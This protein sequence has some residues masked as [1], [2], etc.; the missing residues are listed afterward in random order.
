MQHDGPSDATIVAADSP[1]LEQPTI[2]VSTHLPRISTARWSIAEMIRAYPS[3][4]PVPKVSALAGRAILAQ[5]IEEHERRGTPLVI[6]DYN[7]HS[8]W[9]HEIFTLEWLLQTSGDQQ[10][11]V[12]NMHDRSDHTMTLAEFV[13]ISRA[14]K[15]HSTPGELRRLYWK[16]ADCPLPWREWL[17]KKSI[18]SPGVLPGSRDDYLGYLSASEAVESLLCYMGIGDTYTAAHKDLCCSSGHNLMCFAEENASSYWFMTAADDASAAARYFHKELKQELDW[19]THV[20]SLEELGKAPFPVYVVEQCVG[21]LILVPPR[22]C[23]QVV[24]SGGLA[25]KTSWS[26]M[27][28]DSL[29]TALHSELPIYRRVCRPEQYRAALSHLVWSEETQ[30]SSILD[31]NPSTDSHLCV[32]LPL[33]TIADRAQ[34]LRRLVGLFDEVLRDEYA[35]CHAQLAHVFRPDTRKGW[36]VRKSMPGSSSSSPCTGSSS[37][38]ITLQP[39][40]KIDVNWESNMSQE[41]SASCNLACDFCGADIFQS[42]FECKTCQTCTDGS[43]L[44]PGDGLLICPA[45]YVEGRLCECGEMEPV[46][47]RS[48]DT[49]LSDRNEAARVLNL[50]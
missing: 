23:H 17:L 1:P 18:V 9:P 19:E 42:F 44:S 39:P 24:N 10:I 26:R 48:F 33:E 2:G 37:A 31:P 21:D 40:C 50:A 35:N 41:R 11:N 6:V 34:K 29:K 45:C 20:T 36:T 30:L 7:K 16:D 25:M 14:Q 15:P 5:A 12:R 43:A 32:P 49:L 4:K 22:S 13:E 27:T 3:F 46:Q 28:L 38:R 47:C 8:S